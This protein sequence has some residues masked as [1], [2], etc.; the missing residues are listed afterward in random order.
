MAG[1][2]REVL[3][4]F[5]EATKADEKLAAKVKAAVEARDAAALAKLAQEAGFSLVEDDFSE[6]ASEL[7]GEELGAVAGGEYEHCDT[8]AVEFAC[9][10]GLGIDEWGEDLH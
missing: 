3:K 6:P 10:I 9:F 1:S 5:V 7:S 2:K 8:S 4:A